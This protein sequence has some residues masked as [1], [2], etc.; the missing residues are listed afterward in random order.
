VGTGTGDGFLAVQP[1]EG[2][3]CGTHLSADPPTTMALS[4]PGGGSHHTGVGQ[5]T[6]T[7]GL[8]PNHEAS[9]PRF[10]G[11]DLTGVHRGTQP[12]GVPGDD[13]VIVPPELLLSGR[14]MRLDLAERIRWHT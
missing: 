4:Q 9:E 7:D 10:A 13:P 11:R 5:A 1:G 12:L 6:R 2:Q 14:K 8:L 3:H